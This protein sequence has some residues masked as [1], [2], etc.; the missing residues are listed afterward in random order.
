MGF[1][2]SGRF[3]PTGLPALFSDG[4]PSCRFGLRRRASETDR[5]Q[6]FA[7]V[8][9]VTRRGLLRRRRAAALVGFVASPRFSTNRPFRRSGT[10]TGFTPSANRRAAS[11]GHRPTGLDRPRL[12]RSVDDLPEVLSPG[13]SPRCGTGRSLAMCSRGLPACVATR[14]QRP[15]GRLRFLVVL[16]NDPEKYMFMK[17]W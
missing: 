11:R 12:R 9:V 2:P 4:L 7:P 5:L 6:G 8:V 16:S 3:L 14:P 1:S 13:P 10:P 17:G 15:F